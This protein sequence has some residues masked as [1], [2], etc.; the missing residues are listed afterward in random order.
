MFAV[1]K[2]SREVIYIHFFS[3]CLGDSLLCH[4]CLYIYALSFKVSKLTKQ[5]K[6]LETKKNSEEQ[7][8]KDTQKQLEELQCLYKELKASFQGSI[9]MEEHVALVN[10]LN[11]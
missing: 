4:K 1:S 6:I 8:L 10:K 9:T 11:R 5:L 7:K 2:K 3:C